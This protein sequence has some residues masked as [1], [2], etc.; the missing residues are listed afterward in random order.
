[1][2]A[3]R[4]AGRPREKGPE[5][6]GDILA[7]LFAVRGWGRRQEML[8]L[9]EAWADTVGP[10]V[11]EHTRLAG[12]RRGVLEVLVDSAI[13]HQELSNFRRR[14]L[15]EE[16]RRRL[17]GATLTDLRFRAGAWPRSEL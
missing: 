15:L 7:Q 14:A 17:P 11:I 9:E 13:M 10:T 3:R 8:R 4:P 12:L 2:K 5:R 6:L 16:L 1:M